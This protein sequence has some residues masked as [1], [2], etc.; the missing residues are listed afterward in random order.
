MGLRLAGREDKQ[1][2]VVRLT[3]LSDGDRVSLYLWSVSLD[4]EPALE[5]GRLVHQPAHNL[6]R[7]LAVRLDIALQQTRALEKQ[8]RRHLHE[9]G[10]KYC[11]NMEAG[12][13]EKKG[14]G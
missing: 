2:L 4:T 1:S 8:I 12:Y 11:V 5:R 3:A 13:D 10:C 14:A 6:A 9:C 7:G